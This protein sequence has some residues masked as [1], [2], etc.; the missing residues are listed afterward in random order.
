MA[1]AEGGAGAG[2]VAGL[3]PGVGVIA[4]GVGGARVQ[5]VERV[6]RVGGTGVAKAEVGAGPGR[7]RLG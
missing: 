5:G 2:I 1:G 3:G 4:L 7:V 6:G